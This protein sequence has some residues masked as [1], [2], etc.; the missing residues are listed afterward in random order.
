[1]GTGVQLRAGGRQAGRRVDAWAAEALDVSRMRAAALIRAGV[2]KLNGRT[3]KPHR[4]VRSGDV[5]E[6]EAPPIPET[7]VAGEPGSAPVP[8]VFSDS[9]LVVVDKPAGLTVHPGAGRRAGTLVNVLLGMGIPLAPA[10]GRLRPGVVHRLDRETSG[11]LV[12]AR[13]D[14]AYWK[15][16][17]MVQ[18]RRLKREYLAVVRGSP[19][20]ARG[21]IDA[22]LE[23]DPRNREKFAVVSSGGK[24]AVTHYRVERKLRDASLVRITLET[25]RTHQIRVHFSALGWPVLGDRVYGGRRSAE[26]R[27]AMGRHALHAA[28]LSFVHPV[29]RRRLDLASEPPEDMRDLIAGLDA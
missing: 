12:L 10:A 14:A 3:V 23:R 15:L 24:N 25:G 29:T 28:R 8:V 4:E 26:D 18:R 1:M 13:T 20:P 16:A 27:P 9:H 6:G 19:C 22:A 5:L 7:K 17:K 2:V 11:L 21:T